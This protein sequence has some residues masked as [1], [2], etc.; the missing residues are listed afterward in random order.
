M[1]KV[2]LVL[3]FLFFIKIGFGQLPDGSIA[4]NFTL[5]DIHGNWH[6]LYDYLDS[7]KTVLINLASTYPDAEAGQSFLYFAEGN[8]TMGLHLL[9]SIHHAAASNLSDGPSKCSHL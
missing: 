5:Q 3:S 6:T 7:G 9:G 8:M 2:T 4:P 1:N